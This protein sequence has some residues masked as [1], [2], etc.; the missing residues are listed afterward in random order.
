MD[1]WIVLVFLVGDLGTISMFGL[2]SNRF[3][4]DSAGRHQQARRVFVKI[5]PDEVEHIIESILDGS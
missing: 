4:M 5:F 2:K 1:C 3:A